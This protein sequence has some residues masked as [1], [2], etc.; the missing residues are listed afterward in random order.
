MQKLF[1]AGCVILLLPGLA[2]LLGR[3]SMLAAAFACFVGALFP[4]VSP[5]AS[6][7]RQRLTGEDR[8]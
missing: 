4:G 5:R 6:Q 8:S 7:S 2:Q 3:Y 1:A